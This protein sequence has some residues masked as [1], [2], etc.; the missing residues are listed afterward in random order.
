MYEGLEESLKNHSPLNKTVDDY[1]QFI[2]SGG[3]KTVSN[4]PPPIVALS[5]Y[6]TFVHEND[7]LTINLSTPSA[8]DLHLDF[9]PATNAVVPYGQSDSEPWAVQYP[10]SY[11]FFEK[12]SRDIPLDLK[13]TTRLRQR[14]ID[15][16]DS[17]LDDFMKVRHQKR[18]D[19]EFLLDGIQTTGVESEL[20]MD[21]PKDLQKKILTAAASYTGRQP[22]HGSVSNFISSA[23]LER[24]ESKLLLKTVD[25]DGA[26]V[27]VEIP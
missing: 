2:L 25:A 12:L 15:L 24:I 3:G 13:T 26:E 6:L 7:R 10:T 14:A 16:I 27:L 5:R 11:L 19:I 18:V 1:L 20:F 22:V 8:L 21:L 4:R 17:H 23:T 9:R